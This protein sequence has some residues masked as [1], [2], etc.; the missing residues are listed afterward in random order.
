MVWVMVTTKV[1]AIAA[2]LLGSYFFSMNKRVYAW[3]LLAG[4]ISMV[5]ASVMFIFYFTLTQDVW[6]VG[7]NVF[8][9]MITMYGIAVNHRRRKRKAKPVK[10]KSRRKSKR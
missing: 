4:M 10:K 7:L 1:L 6:M 3:S 9:L 8:Y 2:S 5:T